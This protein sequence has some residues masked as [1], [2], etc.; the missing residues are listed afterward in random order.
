MRDITQLK[1]LGPQSQH[2]LQIIGIKTIEDFLVADVFDLYAKLKSNIP[3]VS[4]NMLY[5][6]IGAQEDR[7]W[8]EIKKERRLE[9]LLRLEEM[10][11]LG[12]MHSTDKR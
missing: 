7:H 1:G 11:L 4:L 10:N 2:M 3:N 9:I 12:E 5:A 8:Q 6:M